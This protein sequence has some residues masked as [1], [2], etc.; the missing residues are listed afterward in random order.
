MLEFVPMPAWPRGR[1]P[2]RAEGPLCPGSHWQ[3]A[4]WVVS[5]GQ[6]QSLLVP[7]VLLATVQTCVNLDGEKV[8]ALCVARP[9][10]GEQG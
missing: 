3:P 2:V 4:P 10:G 6:R 8:R 9:G 1:R 7:A 5:L